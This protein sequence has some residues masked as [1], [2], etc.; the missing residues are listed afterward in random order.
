MEKLKQKRRLVEELHEGKF[1]TKA[2][3]ALE[4]DKI[5]G[6]ILFSKLEVSTNST[7]HPSLSFVSLAPLGVFQATRSE[8]LDLCW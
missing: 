3:V 4:R 5:V 2:L 6:H 7:L 1:V 8:A